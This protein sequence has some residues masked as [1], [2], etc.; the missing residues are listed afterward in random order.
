M[1][2]AGHA[3]SD[4]GVVEHHAQAAEAFDGEVDEV[5]D[6]RRLGDVGPLERGRRAE[7]GSQGTAPIG[8][9]VGDDDAG[10]FLH[11]E[12]SGRPADPARAAADDGDPSSE[13]AAH[14][15][16]S[17]PFRRQCQ[18]TELLLLVPPLPQL[19]GV[20]EQHRQGPGRI[21]QVAVD[22]ALGQPHLGEPL[23]H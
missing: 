13:L 4:P 11:E 1:E 8:I 3:A 23:D 22:L 20:C 16:S 12:L 9:D 10:S 7:G 21:V 2:K 14:R 6:L 17:T 18:K 5:L 15:E 19:Q